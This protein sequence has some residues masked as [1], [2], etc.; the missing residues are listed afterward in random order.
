MRNQKSKAHQS[1]KSQDNAGKSKQQRQM[2]YYSAD[3]TQRESPQS[4][5]LNSGASQ[6]QSP[7]S[8]RKSP[9]KRQDVLLNTSLNQIYVKET[10]GGAQHSSKNH[11]R[12]GQSEQ[13]AGSTKEQTDSAA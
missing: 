8:K 13:P 12:R 7:T 11:Q 4:T 1:S 2:N 3:T 9:T 10:P 6:S 5:A